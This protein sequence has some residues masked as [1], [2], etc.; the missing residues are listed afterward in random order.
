MGVK[1]F[2]DKSNLADDVAIAFCCP[3]YSI[4]LTVFRSNPYSVIG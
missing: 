1:A 2:G 4:N 3:L